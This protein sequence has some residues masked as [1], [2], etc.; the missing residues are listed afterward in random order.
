MNYTWNEGK[1]KC[2]KC[3]TGFLIDKEM[4]TC[5]P[6]NLNFCKIMLSDSKCQECDAGYVSV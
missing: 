3:Q 6:N 4:K 5:Y 2:F 1:L